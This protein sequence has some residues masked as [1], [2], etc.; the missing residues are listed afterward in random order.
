[1]DA[2]QIIITGII[3]IAIA[4][5]AVFAYKKNRSNKSNQKNI[6][7]HGNGK[8]VGGDDNSINGDNNTMTPSK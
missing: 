4:G 1:M 2:L 8:V 6:T 7:I 3:A 5:G